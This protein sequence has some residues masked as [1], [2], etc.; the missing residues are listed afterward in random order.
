ML[1]S[2]TL[3]WMCIYILCFC[4]HYF[5]TIF[6]TS[7]YFSLHFNYEMNVTVKKYILLKHHWT[8]SALYWQKMSEQINHVCQGLT[9]HKAWVERLQNWKCTYTFICC[10]PGWPQSV[11][12]YTY[13]P[14]SHFTYKLSMTHPHKQFTR[15]LNLMLFLSH[16]HHASTRRNPLFL[17]HS[18]VL[19]HKDDGCSLVLLCLHK[20]PLHLY[21][22]ISQDVTV[23]RHVK[24]LNCRPIN[25]P[26][27]SLYL[28]YHV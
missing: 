11:M 8:Y 14:T 5:H 9:E 6:I 25:N 20:I 21:V 28:M 4:Q 12:W 7:H 10:E 13:I 18:S 16:V 15:H 27:M 24:A 17:I 22:K 23:K 3:Y 1:C 2:D 19:W 26:S